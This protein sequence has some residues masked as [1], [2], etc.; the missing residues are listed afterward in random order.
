[1]KKY[2]SGSYNKPLAKE[3]TLETTMLHRMVLL[4]PG[5]PFLGYCYTLS[6]AWSGV[7]WADL[8]PAQGAF[9]TDFYENDSRHDALDGVNATTM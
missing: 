3:V 9:G 5:Y 7:N 2:I 4:Y 1:L 8:M 6:E